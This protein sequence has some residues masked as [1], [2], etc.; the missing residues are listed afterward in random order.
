MERRWV[1]I[2]DSSELAADGVKGFSVGDKRIVVVRYRGRYYAFDAACPHMA[3]PLDEGTIVEGRLECPWHHYL[4]DLESG[5]N[6]YPKNVYP[7]DLKHTVAPLR[8][9]PIRETEGKLWVAL[10][11][12]KA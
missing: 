8:K 10:E 11:D 2:A 7:D 1:T 3:G 12:A 4:Y 9:Y 6:Y 5:E